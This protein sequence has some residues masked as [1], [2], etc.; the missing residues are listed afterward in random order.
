MLLAND[1]F[2]VAL[3]RIVPRENRSRDSLVA[4]KIDQQPRCEPTGAKTVGAA[5]T[6]YQRISDVL[7]PASRE[8]DGKQPCDMGVMGS[9][10]CWLVRNGHPSRAPEN[11]ATH[12]AEQGAKRTSAAEIGRTLD[13]IAQIGKIINQINDIQNTIAS[14]VEEQTATTAEIA[15][16]VNEAA[17]G[18]R[19]IAQNVMGVAQAASSTTEGA[20]NTKGSADELA[21]MAAELQSLV[22]KLQG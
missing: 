7:E 5:A 2:H 21:K 11:D 19:E 12:E 14:A 18:S 17:V 16:S 22:T 8:T 13:A 1:R 4:T 9:I 6:Q 15:R 20:A 10:E 3:Q